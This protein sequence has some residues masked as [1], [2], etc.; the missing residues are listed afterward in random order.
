MDSHSNSPVLL[1]NIAGADAPA[2]QEKRVDGFIG[3][4]GVMQDLYEKIE[5][6]A[7][8]DATVFI[9]GETGTGKEVCA[10]TV[11]R[12]SAR[13]D[14]PFIP[15]NCAA[16]PRDLMESELFGH[17]KGAFTG[18]IADRDGAARLADGGTLFLDEIAEMSFD[19]Q[20]K[21]LRFLQNLS[22]IKVGGSRIEKTDAR[23]ICA[24]NRNPAEEIRAVR[25]REDLYYRLHVLP[26]H[27]PPLRERGCDVIDIAQTLLRDYAHVE[28]RDFH[29]F[30]ADAENILR[31]HKW[32]G[33]IRELQNIVRQAVVM[34]GGS[35]VT[36]RMLETLLPPQRQPLRHISPVETTDHIPTLAETERT[37]VERAIEL[38]GGNIGRAAIALDVSPSTIYR[39]KME[40]EKTAPA[41][42]GHGGGRS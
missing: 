13:K 6:A 40:W 23:I 3:T 30:T 41:A 7:H 31:A 9:T 39:K 2:R 27:M 1:R 28:K 34:N 21:L 16:I 38:C 37:A 22:F 4:S 25:F 8:S 15:I 18:A 12:I 35:M 36:G 26:L 11:H 10:E 20:S 17:V 19:M 33:N 42:P 29:G 24:T 32:P 5:N 14:K